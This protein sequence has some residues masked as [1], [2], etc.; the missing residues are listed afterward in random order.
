MLFLATVVISYIVIDRY[1]KKVAMKTWDPTKLDGKK[2]RLLTLTPL[3]MTVIW[4][5]TTLHMEV[6]PL[7]QQYIGRTIETEPPIIITER[8]VNGMITAIYIILIIT[9]IATA[10]YIARPSKNKEKQVV[11]LGLV[12]VVVFGHTVFGSSML[13]SMLVMIVLGSI[14]LELMLGQNFGPILGP[15]VGP[16][17][18]WPLFLILILESTTKLILEYILGPIVTLFMM[19]GLLIFGQVFCL[20]ESIVEFWVLTSCVYF[21]FV[22]IRVI[23]FGY[24]D[25]IS[26]NFWPYY[27]LSRLSKWKFLRFKG[28]YSR[29]F[30]VAFNDLG[31]CPFRRYRS[32]KDLLVR[33]I[34][35]SGLE[36]IRLDVRAVWFL[37]G[38]INNKAVPHVAGIL[39]VPELTLHDVY[40]KLRRNPKKYFSS[41]H[42]LGLNI[43]KRLIFDTL[44]RPDRVSS[45]LIYN[46]PDASEYLEKY[47]SPITVDDFVSAVISGDLDVIYRAD[48]ELLTSIIVSLVDKGRKDLAVRV[49]DAWVSGF[50]EHYWPMASRTILG[51]LDKMKLSINDFVNYDWFWAFTKYYPDL[52]ED[53]KFINVVPKEV[54]CYVYNSLNYEWVKKYVS[55]RSE[56]NECLDQPQ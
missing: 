46:V 23:G 5:L 16:I 29:Y 37:V 53:E 30:W 2:L 52:L 1:I 45:L 48:I 20:V 18:L 55:A 22:D 8:Q 49:I 32:P 3:I 26:D 13:G 4:V 35:N 40:E 33:R 14:I 54:F 15:I 11:S 56:L 7:L 9:L 21:D 47:I 27:M 19:L 6:M 31:D 43:P 39:G 50:P 38:L 36:P 10:R 34:K 28:K 41:I 24:P 17:I 25:S 42:R 44:R 51:R 12:L